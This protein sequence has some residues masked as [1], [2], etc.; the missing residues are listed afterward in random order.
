[1]PQKLERAVIKIL[2]G[3]NEGVERQV[4]FN[5]AEYSLEI[6]NNF[7]EAALPGLANPILQFVNGQAQTLSMELLFDTWTDGGGEDVSKITGTFAE[8]LAID[9]DLHAPPPVEFK[10]GS[11]AFKAVVERLTQR[12]TMFNADGRPVRAT[13]S[14]TFKQY[15]TLSEQLETPRRSSADR[16]KRRV[17]T[18]DDSLWAMAA[19]EYGDPRY[20]RVV[21]RHNGI[22]NPRLLE[23]G[24]VVVLP[25]L[26]DLNPSEV[27]DGSSGA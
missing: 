26:E 15:R 14:I 23:A 21:A 20:W 11:C 19:R 25:A 24:E 9:A 3:R 27:N 12:F 18:A 8:M 7:Q 17:L 2:A 13:L 1:M 16:T 22:A 4:L 6:S 5:P 10:W